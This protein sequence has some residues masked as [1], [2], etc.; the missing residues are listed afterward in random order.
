MKRSTFLAISSLVGVL[1]GLAIALYPTELMEGNGVAMGGESII[2]AR[3]IGAAILSVSIGTWFARNA[4]GSAAMKGLLWIL[5]LM[6]GSSLVIDLYYYLQGN[7]TASVFGS[8]IIHVL[9]GA[10]AFYYLVKM[11]PAAADAE[12]GAAA[13]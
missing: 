11:E 3:A 10:G 9:F 6:H 2:L 13:A 5:T 4:S 1:F 8:V 7:L 12:R